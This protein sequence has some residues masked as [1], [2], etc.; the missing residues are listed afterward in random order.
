M[1]PRRESRASDVPDLRLGRA[2]EVALIMVDA[3]SWTVLEN[4]VML[5][6]SIFTVRIEWA[7]S[8]EDLSGVWKPGSCGGGGTQV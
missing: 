2:A 5:L 6:Y 3:L 8:W 7:L 4:P 1:M